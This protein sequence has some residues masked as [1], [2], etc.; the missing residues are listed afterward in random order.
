[1][2]VS[3]RHRFIFAAVPKTGTHAVRQALREQMGDEDVEQVG[4][5][6]NRRFPWAD[7]AAIQHGH[8]SLQQV[9]PYLGEEAFADYFKFAF[10]RNPFDRFISYCAFMLRG[11][12][13]FQLRPQEVMRHFLFRNPQNDHILFQ[14]QAS[15]LVD[16]NGTTLLTDAVGRVE[17]MQTSFDAICAHIGMASRPLD[18]VNGTR[19]DDYR[20]Y[21]DKALI[22]GVTAR[23][24]QD[25][26]L[27]GYSFEGVR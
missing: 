12:N 24:A 16:E 1:M 23:Y 6:V 18:R 19:H 26:D 7:L 2:I 20:C 15:L 9:R 17:D 22:D 25:L 5:F 27:F 14:P 8:L 21:Y 13:D 11:G 10:V 3:H 4:L